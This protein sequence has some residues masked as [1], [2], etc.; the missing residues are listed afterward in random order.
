MGSLIRILITM[1]IAAGYVSS[2]QAQTEQ[3]LYSFNGTGD[4]AYPQGGLVADSSGNLYGTTESGGGS[5]GCGMMFELKRSNGVLTKL[6]VW[7]FQSGSSTDGC[8]PYAGLILDSAG[9]FYGT[10]SAGG[11]YGFG[12]A[13]ELS[14][15]VPGGFTEKILWNF[16]NGADGRNPYVGL[17]MDT[18]GHLYG[19]TN[20]GGAAG[21]TGT[22][23][24]LSPN[25]NG[26][27]SE[28]ILHSFGCNAG[29][30]L[31]PNAS[32]TL[33][34]A[35]NIYG[36]TEFGGSGTTCGTSGCGTIYELVKASAWAETLIYF[37]PGGNG[38]G[39]PLGP[40]IFDTAG[41]LYGTTSS[42]PAQGVVFELANLG[43][44]WGE[45]VVHKFPAQTGDGGEPLGNLVLNANKVYGVTLYAGGGVGA[46]QC[47]SVFKLTHRSSGWVETILYTFQG[48]PLADGASPMSGLIMDAAGNLYGTTKYGGASTN[49]FGGCGV[50][51]EVTP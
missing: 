27:W 46:C 6:Q 8:H 45:K 2:A 18:S 51:F 5:T 36:T 40:V 24:Q 17:T 48:A 19:T 3:V 47:G 10:T 33:D 30:G 29:D 44:S 11:T 21:C 23:F 16:G 25:S 28:A 50:V 20:S 12:T 31:A 39:F 4:G 9:N 49:C 37:F 38:G 42:Y 43:S 32:V 15:S 13:F 1:G 41:H 14:P 7:T 26:S 22:V 34:A 35:G